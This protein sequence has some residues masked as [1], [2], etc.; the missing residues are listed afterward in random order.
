V[1]LLGER[2]GMRLLGE[3]VED[4]QS[5]RREGDGRLHADGEQ[6]SR[7]GGAVT[8]ESGWDPD[9]GRDWDRDEGRPEP[10]LR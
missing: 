5:E 3:R 9:E 7:V 1:Q 8:G 4:K 6:A 2:G 10:R